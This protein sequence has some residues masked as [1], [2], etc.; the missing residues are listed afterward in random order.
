MKKYP[1]YLG[2]ILTVLSLAILACNLTAE[3][4][5]PELAMPSP[6]EVVNIA[7]TN[8]LPT[9]PTQPA[10]PAPPV[11]TSQPAFTASKHFYQSN[12]LGGQ[13]SVI[14]VVDFSIDKYKIF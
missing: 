5:Q 14:K 8:S 4:S 2:V 3:N 7:P 6:T 10:P 13:F 11:A 12:C 1:L 9:Q